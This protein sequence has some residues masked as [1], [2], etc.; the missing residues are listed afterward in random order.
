MLDHRENG[1]H[2]DPPDLRHFAEDAAALVVAGVALP[3]AD[4]D[5]LRLTIGRDTDLLFHRRRYGGWILGSPITHMASGL[6]EAAPGTD[7]RR[8]HEPL[9]EYLMLVVEPNITRMG[10]YR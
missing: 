3:P 1:F 5:S 4:R 10:R 8:L 9:R 7:D 2:V 6:G